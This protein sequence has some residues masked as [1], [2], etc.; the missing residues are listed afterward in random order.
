MYR[1]LITFLLCGAALAQTTES[2]RG[3][4]AVSKTVLWASGAGGIYLQTTNGGAHWTAAKVP[5]AESLDFRGIHAFSA[6]T[7]L[8]MSAGSGDKSKIY[9]TTD[10][11]AH[12]TMVFAN[13]DATGFFDAMAFSDAK[14]G[15][16]AGDQV[17][18]EMAIFTTDDAGLH[19][20][21]RHTP[22]ALTNE[23][24]F[25]ASNSCL[26]VRGKFAWF[27]TGAGRIL[28]SED[29]GI[30]WSAFSTPIRHDSATAGVF[31]VAFADDR[32]GVAVGGDYAHDTEARDNVA[33]TSDGGRTWNAPEQGPK[34]FRSAV[35]HICGPI[36][37]ATGTSGSDV[38]TDAGKT[39]RNF[40]GRSFHALA[41]EWAV[42][43]KGRMAR[44][45]NYL[46]AR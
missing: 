39:W 14:H 41:G 38:S 17:N 18:G 33:V 4:S 5:G 27:G 45:N 25:A 9:K 21:R 8:L 3:I 11:G 42:G 24:G 32:R 43:E 20:T 1:S 7:A 26:T 13:P 28:R 36:W 12:W 23:G 2:L 35:R 31:S 15:I 22:P 44:L 16:I 30:T 29:R 37:I 46:P 10:A 19:W 40:D 34:G 6:T